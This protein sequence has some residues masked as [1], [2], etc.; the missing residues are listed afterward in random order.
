MSQDN[1]ETTTSLLPS[2]NSFD[3]KVVSVTGVTLV[4]SSMQGKEYSHTLAKDAKLTCDGADCKVEDIKVGSTIRVTTS[5][6]D[7]D[8]ATGVESLD[9]NAKPGQCCS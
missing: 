4:T 5:K 1:E 2:S 3:G 9:E 8:V 6:N 7:H